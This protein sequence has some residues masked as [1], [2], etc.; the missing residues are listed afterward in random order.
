MKMRKTLLISGLAATLVAALGATQALAD[1]DRRVVVRETIYSAPVLAYHSGPLSVYYGSSYYGPSHS[2][3]VI[4]TSHRTSPRYNS[5]GHRSSAFGHAP[6]GKAHGYRSKH[7][8]G[9]HDRHHY[10]HGRNYYDH[11]RHY[12]RHAPVRG[13]WSRDRREVIYVD[14]DARKKS[15]YRR[16]ERNSVIIRERRR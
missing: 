15:N 8:Y 7:G 4:T 6:Y 5:H 16:V 13:S 12:D 1:H 9:G 10:D 14:R 11:D 3:R 2:T